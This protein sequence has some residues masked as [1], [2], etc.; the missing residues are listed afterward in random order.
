MN[1][2]EECVV[3]IVAWD[4]ILM[5]IWELLIQLVWCFVYLQNKCPHKVLQCH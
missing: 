5:L 1:Q 3:S 4:L 2:E